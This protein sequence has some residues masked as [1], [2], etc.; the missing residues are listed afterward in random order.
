MKKFLI[1]TSTLACLMAAPLAAQAATTPQ[2]PSASS[3]AAQPQKHPMARHHA[4]K[5]QAIRHHTA[6]N[7][8][9]A[10]A[11]CPA[12]SQSTA[13]QPASTGSTK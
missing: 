5:H 12:G 1:A 3:E 11:N 9:K 10:K 4:A 13:C 7:Q 2:Q 8:T 6:M